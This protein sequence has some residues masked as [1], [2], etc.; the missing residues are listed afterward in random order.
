LS[1]IKK[2]NTLY[3]DNN[4]AKYNT[5]RSKSRV[6]ADAGKDIEKEVHSFTVGEIAS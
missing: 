1:L 2:S 4:K 6:T 3:R 5:I